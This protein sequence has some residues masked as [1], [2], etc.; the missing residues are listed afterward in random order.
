[1]DPNHI[2]YRDRMWSGRRRPAERSDPVVEKEKMPSGTGDCCNHH[3][4]DMV[5]PLTPAGEHLYDYIG[6]E[7][8][9]VDTDTRT[10]VWTLP[11]LGTFRPFDFWIDVDN[12]LMPKHSL[13]VVMRHTN[14]TPAISVPTKAMVYTEYPVVLGEPNVLICFVRNIFPP[15]I[16]MNWRKNGKKIGDGV[17]ETIFLPSGDLSFRKFLYLVFVPNSDDNYTCEVEHWGL[18]KPTRIIWE[19]V[20]TKVPSE[21]LESSIWVVELAVGIIISLVS[22]FLIMT[23]MRS[24]PTHRRRGNVHVTRSLLSRET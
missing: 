17:T 14:Y 6:N 22:V 19:A 18:D 1:M 3:G 20:K 16:N 5:Q 12:I 9:R 15:A 13:D 10:I 2:S 8:F 4:A 24:N 11:G 23:A 21:M 7:M